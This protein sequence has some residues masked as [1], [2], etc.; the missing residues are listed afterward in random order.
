MQEKHVTLDNEEQKRAI[1]LSR[2]VA[3]DWT[4]HQAAV[5]LG[6]S[7]RQLRRLKKAYRRAGAA[8]LAHGNRRRRPVNA[9]ADE[10]RIEVI[11]L[12]REKYAGFNQQHLTEKLAEDE[13]L[14]L[15]RS[16][17]RRI[18]MEAGL[19]TPRPRRAPKHRSRR[20][21]MP[22]EG[23]LLQADGSRHQWLGP[24]G[25]Y[26]TLIAGTDDATGK[27]PWAV[28]REQE[29][30]QG[31][32]E[33]LQAVVLRHGIPLALYVDRHG[34]FTPNARR[35][36][37]VGEQLAGTRLPT[38]FGRVLAELRIMLIHAQSPQAKEWASHYTSSG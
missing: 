22:Q 2:V 11:A 4:N 12:A 35:R 24:D 10:V 23:M 38:Q 6:V 13:Q 27:V 29:D 26:L 37:S 18:V 28:F 16:T 21:R 17:V 32:M 34:I 1:V 8:A 36:R 31:Y 7:Q 9:I 5:A 20:E 30:A 33:W 25:P 19:P 3:G 15:S 14:P